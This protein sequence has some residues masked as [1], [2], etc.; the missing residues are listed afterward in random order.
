M[1]FQLQSVG[2]P[3]LSIISQVALDKYHLYLLYFYVVR[4]TGRSRKH[5]IIQS[6]A[7]TLSGK[8]KQN[9]YCDSSKEARITD[10]NS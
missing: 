8:E 4:T 10:Q 9:G 3:C 7:Q 1:R 6:K 5:W 2:F